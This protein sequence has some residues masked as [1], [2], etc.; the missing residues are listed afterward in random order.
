[1]GTGHRA[2]AYSRYATWLLLGPLQP[3]GKPAG[4]LG[5][6]LGQP[7][8]RGW[9]AWG[10]AR[11]ASV[12]RAEYLVSGRPPTAVLSRLVENLNAQ[13]PIPGHPEPLWS[14]GMAPG[15]GLRSHA[16]VDGGLM[17]LIHTLVAAVVFEL[18]STCLGD[19]AGQ[20]ASKSQWV[21]KENRGSGALGP[22]PF[23]SEPRLPGWSPPKASQG[24]R[25]KWQHLRP[26]P[27]HSWAASRPTE[28]RQCSLG[29]LPKPLLGLRTV[30][31]GWGLNI[32]FGLLTQSM[33]QDRGR[34]RSGLPGDSSLL[35][36]RWA[37][38]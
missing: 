17:N 32:S 10:N 1:M 35:C 16:P 34:E 38:P 12:G 15:Q 4:L 7:F 11:R 9:A 37:G 27:P 29:P 20:P 28:G 19:G 36:L 8:A 31:S 22:Q 33:E 26:K 21:R 23:Q 30:G 25:H 14:E 18:L 6:E 3:V 24:L 2:R 5:T 13:V